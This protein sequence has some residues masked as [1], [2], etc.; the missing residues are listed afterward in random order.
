MWNVLLQTNGDPTAALARVALGLVMF[1]H[2][3]QH[4]L[5]W[6]GG[7]GYRGTMKW[8]GSLGI[9]PALGALA[10][11]VEFFGSLALVLGVG[12]RVA[13][14]GIL[15]IM[16]VAAIRVHLPQGFFMNWVGRI[17]GEGYEYHLLA[18]ALAL[19][20]MVRGSGAWSLDRLIAGLS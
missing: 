11:F 14:L 4:L 16:L 15:A 8:F 19:V 2:G 3:A 9:P 5:G 10:I 7:Y 6:F 20:V 12:G 17:S 18:S 13:A 1:P